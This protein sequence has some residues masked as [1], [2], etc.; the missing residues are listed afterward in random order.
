[1][2]GPATGGPLVINASGR[3]GSAATPPLI[4]AAGYIRM[5]NKGPLSV[6]TPGCVAGWAAA[7]DRFGTRGLA[8]LLQ[9]A[10][11]LATHGFPIGR[12]LAAGIGSAR[13]MLNEAAQHTFVPSGR[14]P[15]AGELLRQLEL[16]ATLKRIASEGPR[17]MYEGPLGQAIGSYLE[18]EGGHHTPADLVSYAPEWAPPASVNFRDYRVCTTPPNSQGMLHLLGLSILEELDPAAMDRIGTVHAQVEA[19]SFALEA[20]RPSIADPQFA[21]VPLHELLSPELAAQGRARLSKPAVS[22]PLAATAGDTVYLCAADREGMVVSMIQS[23]REGFGSGLMVP[24]TGVVLNNRARDFGL[25][26]DDPN[27]IAPG[28]RPRHTLSPALVLRDGK[29]VS[30]YGTRGGDGQPYTMVQLGWNLLALGMPP[31]AALDAPRW[32]VEP[33]AAGPSAGSIALEGRFPAE[34]AAGLKVLG[35]TVSLIEDFDP[36]CGLASMLQFD[37]ARQEWLGG[38]DPRGEGLA[39]AL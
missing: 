23:L 26:D 32:T 29:P 20:A 12:G 21:N 7:L 4:S 31:Q 39:L 13:P 6:V 30:A 1:M 33:A 17:V 14:V 35:H 9:P 19:I 37:K 22:R 34:T 8:E 10:I 28:K 24:D 11:R 3:A 36:N 15:A 16:A 18:Q 38:A 25:A 2:C 27:Q 5:P